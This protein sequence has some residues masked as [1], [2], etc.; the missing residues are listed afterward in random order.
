MNI[1]ILSKQYPGNKKYSSNNIKF[2]LDN[3][4]Y[5]G[6]IEI[7]YIDSQQRNVFIEGEGL[8]KLKQYVESAYDISWKDFSDYFLYK[9]YKYS[10]GIGLQEEP[11]HKDLSNVVNIFDDRN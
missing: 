9:L 6:Q 4:C 3:G 11:K 1:K 7:L 8:I 2:T 10:R 5:T